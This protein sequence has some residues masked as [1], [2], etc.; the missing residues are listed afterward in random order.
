[1]EDQSTVTSSSNTSS[2]SSTSKT[3]RNKPEGDDCITQNQV[4][5]CDNEESDAQTTCTSKNDEGPDRPKVAYFSG[6]AKHMKVG[7]NSDHVSTEDSGGEPVEAGSDKKDID[8][9]VSEFVEE[10]IEKPK[11]EAE[12]KKRTEIEQQPPPTALIIP[13]DIEMDQI[14]FD[15]IEK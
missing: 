4:K 11:R 10:H 3:Y 5:E 15:E 7:G 8:A 9:Y 14:D 13:A 6:L 1:M 12:N 2:K